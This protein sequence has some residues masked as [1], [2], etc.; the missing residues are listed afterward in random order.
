MAALCLL[1]LVVVVPFLVVVV[2]AHDLASFE[3][4]AAVAELPSES[5]FEVEDLCP[6]QMVVGKS[7]SPII[8][9]R[10]KGMV[11]LTEAKKG[12]PSN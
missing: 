9:S 7:C 12:N 10:S 4:K 6:R 1:D 5:A 2:G 3:V 8:S 11:A